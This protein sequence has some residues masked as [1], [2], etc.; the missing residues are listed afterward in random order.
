MAIESDFINGSSN[1]LRCQSFQR[2][3]TN[4][5]NSIINKCILFTYYIWLRN[6][7]RF[8]K[9]VQKVKISS[10]H[11]QICI[12]NSMI[13]SDIWNKYHEWYFEIVIGNFTSR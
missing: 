13:C 4:W 1:L 12:G 3:H 5:R 6:T 9:Y 2:L 8:T 7:R 10:V 11:F